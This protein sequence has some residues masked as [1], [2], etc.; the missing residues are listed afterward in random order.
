MKQQLNEIKRM[1]QLAG[2]IVETKIGPKPHPK[3][4]DDEYIQLKPIMDEYFVNPFYDITD[5]ESFE[6]E[7]DNGDMNNK[8]AYDIAKLRGF[9]GSFDDLIFN[10]EELNIE[11]NI[12]A[13]Q[14]LRQYADEKFDINETK[15][16]PKQASEEYIL[17]VL[18]N[19]GIDSEYL[20]DMDNEV[21]GGTDEWMD[22]IT[23][24][25]GKDPYV[26]ELTPEDNK[27]VGEFIKAMRDIGITLI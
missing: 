23:E 13:N 9:D 17:Q 22:V 27:K 24:L 12:L 20:N 3:P 18:A 11:Y 1:Q 8:L 25:T 16:G 14:Y 10:N 2:I 7:M 26:D 4:Q 5:R 15:V 6:D 19:N 21:E